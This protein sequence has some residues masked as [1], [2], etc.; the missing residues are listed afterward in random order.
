M[1][2]TSEMTPLIHPRIDMTTPLADLASSS[3]YKD[4]LQN[5]WF[6]FGIWQPPRLRRDWNTLRNE[7]SNHIRSMN[8]FFDTLFAISI[9]HL[10]FELRK[11]Q[12]TAALWHWVEKFGTIVSLW[13][14]TA[15]YSSRFDNDD[16]SHKLFWG[17]YGI[18]VLGMLMH[19]T[20]PPAGPNGPNFSLCI[21]GVYLLLV[22]HYIRVVVYLPRCRIFVTTLLLCHLVCSAVAFA[23]AYTDEYREHLFWV[24]ALSYP[25][26]VLILLTLTGITSRLLY[27]NLDAFLARKRI[28]IPLHI[29]FHIGRFSS[30]I[31]MVLGQLAI[32]IAVH[33]EQGFQ[34]KSGLYASAVVA[35]FLLVTMKL[36]LF[37]VDYYDVDDHAIRRSVPAAIGW[38]ILFP[39]GVG[40]IA[41]IGC[42]VGLLV[43]VGGEAN[44]EVDEDFARKITCESVAMF[45]FLISVQRNMHYIPYTR[46]LNESG[47]SQEAKVL[48][49]IDH[50]QCLIQVICSAVVYMLQFYSIS[51]LQVMIIIGGLLVFLVFIN[52]LD[53]IVLVTHSRMQHAKKEIQKQNWENEKD[54]KIGKDIAD[55]MCT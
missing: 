20:G 31:M 51:S 5:A 26:T 17:L 54:H 42:G 22:L 55:G 37:D 25:W 35:F 34:S 8:A 24:L 2:S 16:L 1:A 29:E 18:G 21:S 19:C 13:L 15:D 52:F 9:T 40:C 14:S 48:T 4:F 3:H 47:H 7:D 43:N 46:L 30:F 50:L 10:G 23:A 45:L 44:F 12:N 27:P 39:M 11:S 28:D 6:S 53:E 33:P 49:G 32:A 41:I 38:L 36:F